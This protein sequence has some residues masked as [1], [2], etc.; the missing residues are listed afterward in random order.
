VRIVRTP[1][2]YL[3]HFNQEEKLIWAEVLELYPR[4]PSAHQPLSKS[5][6][7]PD[8]LANQRLLD[9]ALHEQRAW[10][11]KQIQELRADPRRW[12]H[13][14]SGLRLSLSRADVEWL[15]QVLN[16]IRVGSWIL[17]GS[18]EDMEPKLNQG[19][20]PLYW[21]MEMCDF[22][23]SGLLKALGEE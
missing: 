8:A 5:G 12:A 18:P 6:Q 21:A 20:F 23:Q 7:L 10:N 15:L 3:L 11:K 22:F 2:K 1:E 14:K 9:E 4:I 13:T 16:D 19:T 17:L